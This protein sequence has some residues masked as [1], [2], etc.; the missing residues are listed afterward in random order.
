[1][2]FFKKEE[3]FDMVGAVD[4]IAEYCNKKISIKGT[5]LMYY[6][7]GGWSGFDANKEPIKSGILVE[8]ENINNCNHEPEKIATYFKKHKRCSCG[9]RIYEK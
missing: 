6:E 7:E 9:V 2:K 1:M 3:F 5:R 8:I 4:D